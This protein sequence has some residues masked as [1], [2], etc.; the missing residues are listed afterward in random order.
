MVSDSDSLSVGEILEATGGRLV[1]G[2]LS[3][4]I[5]RFSTDTRTLQ[6][7]SLFVALRGKRFDGHDFLGEAVA[8]GALG[9][10]F[11]D[12]DKLPSTPSVLLIHVE[13]TLAALGE[14]ARAWR[15]R[16]SIP[17]VAVT[18]TN[19]KT[20]TKEMTCSVLSQRKRVLASPGNFNNLVGLPLTLLL[21][22]SSHETAVVELGMSALGEIRRLSEVCQPDVGVITNIGEAHLESLHS[23]EHVARAK[24]ELLLFLEGER[25]AV[26]N[27]DDPRSHS[28]FPQVRGR[29]LTFG[30]SSKADL[31]AD[32][33]KLSASG[34]HFLLHRGREA[35]AI[36]LPAIGFHNVYNA[37]AAAAVG[38]IFGL[39]LGEIAKGLQEVRL[40]P[41]RLERSRLPSG[42]FVVNDAYNANPASMRAAIE[43]FFRVKEG[44]E[45]ILVV[46]DMLELGE[47]AKEAHWEVG[48]FIAPFDPDLLITVG[49]ESSRIGEGAIASGLPPE[50]VY[51]CQDQ[52]EAMAILKEH[53]SENTWILLKASRAMRLE[54]VLDGLR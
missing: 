19:G 38:T 16:H 44:E 31:W 10:L 43:T 24:G 36:A 8:Q 1:A 39:E 22:R 6:P 4:L 30:L 52:A 18:G 14:I 54:E 11:S 41:M 37:L 51:H 32:R 42:A 15:R 45:A 13:D 27:L 33:M 28:L 29:L 34:T 17:L 21:L 26:L 2:R 9:L 48:A 25:A 7:G 3:Q 40:A 5:H 35:I 20:T 53:L 50:K 12:L 23:V 47:R 49:K 46:G